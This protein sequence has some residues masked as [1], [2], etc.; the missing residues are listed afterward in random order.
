MFSTIT[1]VEI[2][3]EVAKTLAK[4]IVIFDNRL[5]YRKTALKNIFFFI[6][7]LLKRLQ[8]STRNSNLYERRH[9]I[10]P[11]SICLVDWRLD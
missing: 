1:I 9:G 11:R 5:H 6:F 7:F 4:E 10:L 3:K 2:A 8:Y